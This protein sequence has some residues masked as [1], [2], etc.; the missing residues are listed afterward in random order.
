M[1]FGD[2]AC[3]KPSTDGSSSGAGPVGSPLGFSGSAALFL[4]GVS[5]QEEGADKK[6]QLRRAARESLA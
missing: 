3:K 5:G 4:R 6:E 2:G 1:K